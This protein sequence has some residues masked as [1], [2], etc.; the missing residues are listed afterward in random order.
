[1]ISWFQCNISVWMVVGYTNTWAVQRGRPRG[2]LVSGTPTCWSI[3]QLNSTFVAEPLCCGSMAAKISALA[4]HNLRREC[5]SI[6]KSL[7]KMHKGKES[8]MPPPFSCSVRDFSVLDSYTLQSYRFLDL[9]GALFS[10]RYLLHHS[11]ATYSFS[12]LPPKQ[13]FGAR[14]LE[15]HLHLILNAIFLETC[16][17]FAMLKEVPGCSHIYERRQRS[18]FTATSH[19]EIYPQLRWLRTDLQGMYLLAWGG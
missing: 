2:G 7:H 19:L 9:I 12:H 8:Q 13:M 4:R 3:A 5:C 15:E 6:Q 14:S 16:K 18:K 11:I 17:W 10:C 1:M